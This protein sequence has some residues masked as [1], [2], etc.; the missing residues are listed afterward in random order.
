MSPAMV[1]RTALLLVACLALSACSWP[2]RTAPVAATP[3]GPAPVLPNPFDESSASFLVNGARFPAGETAIVK[4]C[5]T[6]E[7]TISSAAVVGS[8]GDKRFDEFA[9][10]WA[11]QVR[12]RNVPQGLQT[13]EVC[14]PVRVEI[15]AAPLPEAL[16]GRQS[17]LS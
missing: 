5:V 13:E 2:R 6:P 10:G 3:P 16:P 14:G 15:K 17:A 9:V 4:V 8:S 1:V 12:L 7:G 11:R